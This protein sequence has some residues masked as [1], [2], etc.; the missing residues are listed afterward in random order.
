MRW[1]DPAGLRRLHIAADLVLVSLGWIAAYGLRYQLNETAGYPINTFANYLRALP[2]VVLPWVFTG[3]LF[4][5]YRV[6]RMK[7]V[8]DELQSLFRSTALG[9]LVVASI[10]FFF[11]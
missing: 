3:W 2:L 1:I 9:A 11:R 5:L 7:T 10:G 4:G 6:Q 8:V